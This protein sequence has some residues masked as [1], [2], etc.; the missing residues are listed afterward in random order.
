MERQDLSLRTDR[1]A[2][3]VVRTEENSKNRSL[4]VASTEYLFVTH[5]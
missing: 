1:H 2:K 5:D 3:D 4:Q